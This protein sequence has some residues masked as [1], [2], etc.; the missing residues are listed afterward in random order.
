[1][2]EE[3]NHNFHN[4]GD[5]L[6]LDPKFLDPDFESRPPPQTT[7][8]P[9]FQEDAFVWSGGDKEK[10]PRKFQ[11]QGAESQ[12]RC[13]TTSHVLNSIAQL[14][15]MKKDASTQNKMH[16]HEW[17]PT[18]NGTW[19]SIVFWG[20]QANL[21]PQQQVAF[22]I[23]CA[24]HVLTFYVEAVMIH[25]KDSTFCEKQKTCLEQLARS[26]TM[27]TT[28]LRMFIS[29]PAGSGKSKVSARCLFLWFAK[30]LLFTDSLFGT[31][32]FTKPH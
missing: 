23:L 1:M 15:S 14:N 8:M 9:N 28:P 4:D 20:K 5:L 13:T 6:T 19:Q 21:D 17:R 29:A 11:N 3:A 26:K 32:F 25:T 18:A 16:H 12:L 7:I 27:G 22:Q 31:L 24:T 2:E 10:M 30:R